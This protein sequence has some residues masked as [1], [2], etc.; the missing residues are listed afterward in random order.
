LQASTGFGS[1]VLDDTP[2][3]QELLSRE[4]K[5]TQDIGNCIVFDGNFGIHRG[6]MVQRGERF[7]FQ[8][9]FDI[10]RPLSVSERVVRVSRGFAL[11]MLGKG[12]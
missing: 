8:V 7:V 1:D 10:N 2:L 6:A 4:A 3:S 5:V 11:R 9:I 12:N